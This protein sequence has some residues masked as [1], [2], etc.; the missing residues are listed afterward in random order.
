MKLKF[1]AMLSLPIILGLTG[2][3][4]GINAISG[5]TVKCGDEN[6][7]QL[8]KSLLQDN[9]QSNVKNMANTEDVL[10]DGAALRASTSQIQFN[11]EDVRTSQTDPNSTKVFCV[12]ALSTTLDSETIKRANF[13]NAYYGNDDVD[14]QA[15]QQDIDMDANVITYSLEYSIQPTDDGKNI[16]GQLQNG[17]ELID[18]ISTAVVYALQKNTVQALKAQEQKA[19]VEN[20]LAERRAMEEESASMAAAEAVAEAAASIEAAGELANVSAEKAKAK[21]TMDYKRSEFN[22]LWKSASADVKS[23]LAAGQK[24]WVAERDEICLSRAQE[25]EVAWQEVVR[26]ECI[27]EMLGERYYAVKEYIDTY[28]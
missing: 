21:A 10:I 1:A 18:F 22:E 26:M 11:L 6:S 24:E 3:E 25:A 9:T 17:S 28:E 14:K 23:S 15:F 20:A 27:S 16:Y 8:V 13:V 5:N 12:A 7:L 4:K 19:N 2:C